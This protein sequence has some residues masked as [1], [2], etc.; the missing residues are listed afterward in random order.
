DV[1]SSDLVAI[2]KR[3]QCQPPAAQARAFLFLYDEIAC[4]HEYGF[5]EVDCCVEPVSL[6]Q[7][8][9]Q[10]R[11]FEKPEARHEMPQSVP[12]LVDDGAVGADDTRNVLEDHAECDCVLRQHAGEVY[13]RHDESGYL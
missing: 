4:P 7:R 6:A 9:P 13:V 5:V 11:N 10:I 2:Q 1:C 8:A 12:D 3:E